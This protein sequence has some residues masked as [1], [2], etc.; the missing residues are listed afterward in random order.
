M[1][2]EQKLRD[3]FR[4]AFGAGADNPVRLAFGSSSWDS[5]AHI[6]LVTELETG[7]NV[8]LSPEE[9]TELTSYSKAKEILGRHGVALENR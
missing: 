8:E 7:F 4:N 5:V 3:C 1:T 9:I 6:A 2:D